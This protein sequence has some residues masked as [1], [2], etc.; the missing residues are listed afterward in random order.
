[1]V[2]TLKADW[3]C[4]I[5]IERTLLLNYYGIL[6]LLRTLLSRI[7]FE[8]YKTILCTV[9]WRSLQWDFTCELS[10]PFLF[11]LQLVIHGNLHLRIQSVLFSRKMH[12]LSLFSNIEVG[13]RHSNSQIE[14]IRANF[15]CR[16]PCILC[17][18]WSKRK[19]VILFWNLWGGHCSRISIKLLLKFKCV[20]QG[21][22]H[23][24]PSRITFIIT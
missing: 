5:W 20:T 14:M 21:K 12:I 3:L 11:L 7:I 2:G 10:L 24:K 9:S 8:Y 17:I 15:T 22:R 13:D 23:T 1:M 19:K 4:S 6:N 18:L 16:T